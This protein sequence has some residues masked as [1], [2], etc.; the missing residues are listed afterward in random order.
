MIIID[1]SYVDI[2]L[3][4]NSVINYKLQ[5]VL[6]KRLFNINKIPRDLYET[7][8]A[9]ILLKLNRAEERLRLLNGN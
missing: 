9:N 8:E 4:V 1:K 6:N 3:I 7:V 5:L 2:N